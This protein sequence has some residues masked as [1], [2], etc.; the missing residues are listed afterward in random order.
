[1]NANPK[2]SKIKPV[3]MNFFRNLEN[4]CIFLKELEENCIYIIIVVE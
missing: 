2:A 4:F 1:M 3:P